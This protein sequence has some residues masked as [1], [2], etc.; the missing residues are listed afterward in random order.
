MS[1]SFPEDRKDDTDQ[2]AP[3]LFEKDLT[4]LRNTSNPSRYIHAWNKNDDS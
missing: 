3:L 2:F 1:L 4:T